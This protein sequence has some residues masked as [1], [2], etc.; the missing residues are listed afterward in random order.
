MARTTVV[1][2]NYNGIQYIAACLDSL[3]AGTVTDIDVIV[4]DN[5]SSDGSLALIKERYPQVTLIE[6]VENTGFSYAVNQGIQ[7]SKTPYVFLLN[8]DTEV[9]PDCIEELERFMER[10][11]NV[12]SVGAKMISLHDKDKLDDAGDYYNALGWAFARGKGKSPD[13]YQKDCE[14]FAACA[15]A[16]MYR[17]DA[18]VQV[19]E[20]DVLH[21]AYLEDIDIG[22]RARI[23]GLRNCF[24][25][26][27]IVYHAGSATSGSRYN[28]FKTSLASRNSVYLI[29]K[30]MPLLQVLIN[31]PFLL[32]GFGTKLFFFT[33]KGMGKEYALGLW[34]GIKL[35][36]E[37]DAKRN[38]IRFCAKSM[39]NYVKIQVD[40]W[41]NLF[42][43]LF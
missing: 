23:L 21:F 27:A 34:R 11:E 15:G 18:F 9:A 38:K 33:L 37:K 22:Y 10:E 43:M 30:N 28:T 1:I 14:V 24:A 40:L 25:A 4:V 6:N 16:A 39:H 5:A 31:I 41:V 12:F 19:G 35:C 26:N 17:K 3:Y 13:L 20:F 32:V 36:M 2:P 42:K 7:A 8:N 29:Y